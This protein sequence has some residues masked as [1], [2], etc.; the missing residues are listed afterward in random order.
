MLSRTVLTKH[1]TGVKVYAMKRL[2]TIITI[3]ILSI[4]LLPSCSSDSTD[5]NQSSSAGS[6][7][8]SKLKIVT[9]I[10]PEYDWTKNIIGDTV[11]ANITLMAKKGMDM[12]SYQPSAKDLVTISECDIFIYVGG[13]SD[14]WVSD[15]LDQASN[16][17]MQVI[18][19]MDIL[20]DNARTEELKEGMQKARGEHEGEHEY[21]NEEEHAG[22][23]QDR[24]SSTKEGKEHEEEPEYDEHVWLSLKNAQ[25]FTNSIADALKKADPDNKDRYS[26]NAAAYI[27][28]LQSLDKRYTKIT[29]AAKTK[30]LLFADRFPFR[31]L[32]EDY[33]LDYYAAFAGCSSESAASFETMTFLANKACELGI[34]NI[35]T[36]DGSDHKIA[37]SVIDITKDKDKKILTMDSMQTRT[38]GSYID[39]MKKNLKVLDKALN[40]I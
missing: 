20:G 10:F 22:S 34:K 27:K 15:A 18:D 39:I 23:E 33:Q 13:E 11:D 28:K 35:L 30:T 24:D 12:H 7:E 29:A 9:T 25:I 38:D 2:I 5:K 31:Y 26:A 17:E 4:A 37:R 36:I 19:L 14:E 3:L 32:T 21:E 16:K 6:K 40:N 8:D 1:S